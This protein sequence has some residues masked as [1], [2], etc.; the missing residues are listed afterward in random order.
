[1]RCCLLAALQ[2]NTESLAQCGGREVWVPLAQL[3]VRQRVP[4]AVRV[5]A[6]RQEP[7]LLRL[8]GQSLTQVRKGARADGMSQQEVYLRLVNVS[9][10]GRGGIGGRH[11]GVLTACA[12]LVV[13]CRRRHLEWVLTLLLYN[14][15]CPMPC[16]V[17]RASHRA[18]FHKVNM[19]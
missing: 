10:A 15:T 18:T 9:V 12:G 1:V 16:S 19:I 7:A 4:P 2:Q 11:C 14:Q 17:R 8:S 3:L 6:L 5:V 13:S